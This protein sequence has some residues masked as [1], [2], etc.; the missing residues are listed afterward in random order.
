MTSGAQ[1]A[2]SLLLAASVG[3]GDRVAIEH[4]SYPNAI[5]AVRA[6]G[7]RGV[8]VPVG[9]AGL[10]L[11]LLDST[12]RQA[13]PRMV[14]LTP[15]HHNP[16]GTSLDE[17]AR[18]RVRELARRHRTLVVADETLTDLTLDG[19]APASISGPGGSGLV[20]VGSASKTFWGGL[21]VG[22]IRGP[23]DLV[24]RLATERARYDISTAVLDQLV[25]C[26][27]L[28]VEDEVLATRRPA[29]RAQRDTLLAAVAD[30]LPWQVA[31]PRGGL[32][33]WVDL[34]VPVSSALAAV[35]LQHGVRVVPGP[36]FGLDGSF[37][38]RLRLTFAHDA[39]ALA[40]GVAR[41]GDDAA[42]HQRG[43]RV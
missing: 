29:L 6:S 19:P 38:S 31:P 4:P 8:P 27:L 2:I 22:W 30:A 35:A 12:V 21:R 41:L 10:D 14:Y 23:R 25:T 32:S 1:Q 3:A 39:E 33:A 20:A 24:A 7:A 18:A 34:G 5:S 15:D 36:T 28:D 9:P 37:E 42:P 16:T 11:D 43:Q 40:R 17:E 26:A 13:S